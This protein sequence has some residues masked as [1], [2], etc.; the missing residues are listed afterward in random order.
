MSFAGARCL[1]IVMCSTECGCLGLVHMFGPGLL[2]I[3][4]RE[5]FTACAVIMDRLD[6]ALHAFALALQQLFCVPALYTW[7]N[8]KCV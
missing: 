1:L 7:N 2:A 5:F 8:D 4:G 3:A 6:C